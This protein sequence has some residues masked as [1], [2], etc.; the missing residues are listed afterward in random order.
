MNEFN[1]ENT[2]VNVVHTL[3]MRNHKTKIS[4]TTP[5]SQCY[6]TSWCYNFDLKV[7]F[8]WQDISQLQEQIHRIQAKFSTGTVKFK[9]L[10]FII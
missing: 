10:L 3:D 1:S 9:Y 6:S 4:L 7:L 8:K 2:E 5:R